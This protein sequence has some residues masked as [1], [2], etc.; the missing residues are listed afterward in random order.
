M[1]TPYVF[2]KRNNHFGSIRD[3][4]KLSEAQATSVL[5]TAFPSFFKFPKS[6]SAIILRKLVPLAGLCDA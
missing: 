3:S 2:C 5:P 6:Q 4:Q 1:T